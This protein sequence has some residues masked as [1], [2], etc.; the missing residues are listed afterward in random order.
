M[1]VIALSLLALQVA[2]PLPARLDPAHGGVA[3]LR[4][5]VA[6][7]ELRFF[8]QWREAFKLSVDARDEFPHPAYA[9]THRATEQ[10]RSGYLICR[11]ATDSRFPAAVA[12]EHLIASATS[13][14][15]A[16]P[17]WAL[18]DTL[19]WNALRDVD[20]GIDSQYH[21]AVHRARG[22]LAA[23]AGALAS[24]APGDDWLI[25]QTV[26]LLVAN[27]AFDE[28][29][30]AA[31]GCRA[32]V[33]WCARL[34]GYAL[35]ERGDVPAADSAFAAASS[36]MREDERCRWTDVSPL[37]DSSARAAYLRVP[38]AQ[39]D[40]ANAVIWWLADPLYIEAGN[41]SRVQQFARAVDLELRMA[42]SRDELYD[43]RATTGG[44]ALRAMFTRYGSPSY[45]WPLNILD[46]GVNGYP[47]NAVRGSYATFEYSTGRVHTI[48]SAAALSDPLDASSENWTITDPHAPVPPYS[49]DDDA[50][51]R[52][53]VA[54][55]QKIGRWWPAE[56]FAPH[57]PI[58]QLPGGQVAMLRRESG[59]VLASAVD[60]DPALL[61]RAS[62]D[63]VTASLVIT[64]RP[65]EIV[66][67]A[68]GAGTVGG[69]LVL[70]GSIP[71]QRTLMA[72]EFPAGGSD[73][74]AAGR[75]RFGIAPPATLAE[76]PSR[77]VA[78]SDPVILVAP[79]D[80]SDLPTD[81]DQAM[82]RMAGSTRLPPRARMGVYWETYGLAP[83]DS[84]EIAVWI[85]RFTPQG[86]LRRFGIALELATDLNTPVVQ[87]W[88]E[89]QIGRG[90][91]TLPGRVP[92]VGRTIILDTS[93]LA[94][95]AYWLD[96]VIRRPG[97]EPARG[98]RSFTVVTR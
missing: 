28:A 67:V 73:G 95:G 50:D 45:V 62:G 48:P 25:G 12:P 78:V 14:F 70:R 9:G 18:S 98:R 43:W 29:V 8:Y 83:A 44:D 32:S 24:E 68:R 36:L 52:A 34:V 66:T 27:R 17:S 13:V 87:S 92:V 30:T 90:A 31:Q 64:D 89:S 7:A 4:D 55:S 96:V 26:R 94:P 23:F 1:N 85:E 10:L 2:A 65:N 63:R 54:L 39:R 11:P 20:A 88:T 22:S 71:S 82:A 57:A 75:T 19:P 53:L 42:L 49:Y 6:R 33:A 3:S 5:S 97:S 38:C 40:S 84:A 61:D 72:L 21:N 59:I 79:Q 58:V 56:H 77:A 76:L 46:I 51:T 69:V 16:C 60:L 80:G 74:P 41:E 93:R 15:V 86:V 37:L 91:F 81:F 35:A 47:T